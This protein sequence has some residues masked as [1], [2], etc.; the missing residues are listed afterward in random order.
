[1]FSTDLQKWIR[2]AHRDIQ[3][4][5]LI[6]LPEMHSVLMILMQSVPGPKDKP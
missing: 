4:L 5:V 2:D 6:Q 1:M 3:D